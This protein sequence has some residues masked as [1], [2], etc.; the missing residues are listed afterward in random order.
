MKKIITVLTTTLVLLQAEKMDIAKCELTKS[1][2]LFVVAKI[3]K[4]GYMSVERREQLKRLIPAYIFNCS[5]KEI[6]EKQW[7]EEREIIHSAADLLMSKE[8][9]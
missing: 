6:P 2:T 8:L 9:R 1:V 4:E 5:T 3:R 7:K